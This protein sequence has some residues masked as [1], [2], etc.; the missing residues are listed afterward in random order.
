MH[1]S[2]RRYR[3]GP[4]ALIASMAISAGA[5]AA[6]ESRA[7]PADAAAESAGLGEI[8]VTAQKRTEDVKE[9]PASISVIGGAALE[10]SHIEGFEDI[11]R[12]VPG[13]SFQAGATPSRCAP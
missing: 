6:I 9:V 13:V 8:I 10:E 7:D 1:V 5:L 2:K 3:S 4:R 11:S 12:A